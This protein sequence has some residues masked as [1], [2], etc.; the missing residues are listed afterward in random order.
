MSV[1]FSVENISFTMLQ[2][3]K[4]EIF[5]TKKSHNFPLPNDEVLGCS[6]E[7]D[8]KCTSHRGHIKPGREF[9]LACPFLNSLYFF[10]H[11]KDW[12]FFLSAQKSSKSFLSACDARGKD[13]YRVSRKMS[14]EAAV[15]RGDT[16]SF[17]WLTR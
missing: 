6:C 17:S 2:P 5:G 9:S 12:M 8:E 10:C 3:N 7:D 4:Y 11:D 13:F 16:W 15:T 1:V 14:L